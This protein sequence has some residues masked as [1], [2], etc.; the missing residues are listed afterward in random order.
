MDKLR[1]VAGAAAPAAASLDDV[2][3]GDFDPE[4]WD[5]KMAAAFDDSYYDVGAWGLSGASGCVRRTGCLLAQAIC[6]SWPLTAAVLV[7]SSGGR[8]PNASSRPTDYPGERHMPRP[9][10]AAAYRWYFPRLRRSWRACR[11]T[12]TC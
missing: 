12:S 3:D 2:L 5:K 1:Q 8:S 6:R 10:D 11:R 7:H 9:P 4:E